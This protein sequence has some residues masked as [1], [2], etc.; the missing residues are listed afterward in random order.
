M[1]R[2][3]MSHSVV[4]VFLPRQLAVFYCFIEKSAFLFFPP[5]VQLVTRSMLPFIGES[6][7][8]VGHTEESCV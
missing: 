5:V 2:C 6:R 4:A 1:Q 8:K 3:S 7:K